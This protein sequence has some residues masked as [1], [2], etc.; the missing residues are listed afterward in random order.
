MG[1]SPSMG[2]GMTPAIT[3]AIAALVPTASPTRTPFRPR[4][5][6]SLPEAANRA[7]SVM[8]SAEKGA[9]ARLDFLSGVSLG[10]AAHGS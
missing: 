1:T 9:P 4:E 10:S 3:R 7:D 6:G 8:G 2:T 5:P